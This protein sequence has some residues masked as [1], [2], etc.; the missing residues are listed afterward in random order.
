M[1]WESMKIVGAIAALVAAVTLFMAASATA[2]GSNG[3]IVG[4]GP[5]SINSY[6]HQVAFVDY[7]SGSGNQ[8]CGGS[9]VRPRI[10][11]TAAHCVADDPP[12]T[13]LD[14]TVIA[15]ATNWISEG[16]EVPI[17]DFAA[18]SSYNGDT[19]AGFD[20]ALVLL[21]SAPGG[22][23]IKLAGPDETSL[24]APGVVATATGWGRTVDGDAN[25]SSDTLKF[26]N[27]PMLDDP[28]CNVAIQQVFGQFSPPSMVCAGYVAGGQ[29]ACQG[30][31][32]G[33]LTVP[34]AGGEGGVIR[35]AGVTSFG[36]GCALPNNPG[37]YARIGQD[38]LQAW[39]QQVVNASPDPGDVIGSGGSFPPPD[40]CAS[41][42]KKQKALCYCKTRATK[43]A[44][45]KC[46][47]KVI[48]KFTRKKG[49]RRK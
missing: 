39:V 28:Y 43:K 17:V 4:G 33:P 26:A 29:D 44:Q 31:S 40:P 3:K 20:V 10:V 12:A 47:R 34:A 1:N 18:H 46:K 48:R 37:V 9:L 22:T 6:P 15:A 25:S 36:N 19:A 42:K 2:A 8:Y 27:L 5:A 16:V 14:D 11:L 49:K 24:W 23:T 13:I 38:P 35:L 30:D 45:K 21:G 41:L 32:G 7:A